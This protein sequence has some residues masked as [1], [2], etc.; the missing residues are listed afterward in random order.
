[1]SN[2]ATASAATTAAVLA[3]FATNA[4]ASVLF[5][6]SFDDNNAKYNHSDNAWYAGA[7]RGRVTESNGAL[8][9]KGTGDWGNGGIISRKTYNSWTAQGQTYKWTS[10]NVQFDRTLSERADFTSEFAIINPAMKSTTHAVQW[11]NHGGGLYISLA[12]ESD[13]N[14]VSGKVR[15]ANSA[16]QQQSMDG[17][18][19][20]AT[21]A[22]NGYDGSNNLDTYV[23]LSESGATVGFDAAGIDVVWTTQAQGTS[24][25]TALGINWAE[26]DP[27][28]SQ[29]IIN[30]SVFGNSNR[31][32]SLYSQPQHTRGSID[33]QSFS[34][35]DGNYIPNHL[36]NVPSPATIAVCSVI[37]LAR[38][39]RM[40]KHSEQAHPIHR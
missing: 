9:L 21:F 36:N 7:W 19:T 17:V 5:T 28:N 3:I 2:H 6:D 12:Y 23:H 24:S 38:T 39:R 4:S 30:G 32:A 18:S 31:V 20:L 10:G 11:W 33:L 8:T 34:I 40:R 13:T 15:L 37:F 1:M 27:D 16:K 29:G 25:G 35:Q 22:L 26:F 14:T